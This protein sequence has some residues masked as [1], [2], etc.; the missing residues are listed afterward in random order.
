M[1]RLTTVRVILFGVGGV[2]SWCAESLVRTGLRHLTIVDSDLVCESNI[3]RQL[4]ATVETIGQP[5]VEVMRNRLLSINPE[6]D[7][8]AV[9]RRYTAE[10]AS[11]F[12]LDDY[13]FV[14][15]AI[16]SLADKA[17]LIL[18][19]T[20]VGK[21]NGRTRLFSSMGAA[22]R[23]DPLQVRKAEFWH[24]RGDAL[25]RALRNRF[26]RNEEFPAMKFQCVYSEQP[27][28]PQFSPSNF[29]FSTF[30]SQLPPP[31]GSLSQVTMVFGA[32][33]ASMVIENV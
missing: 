20:R 17:H 21:E 12:C 26:K 14:I 22:L 5:K 10:S 6:A 28:R 33:L 8:I 32:T 7:I 27:P 9:N 3:N 24:V 11:D 31:N 2:G 13:D 15:D 29:Q 19:A 16:D 25:A 4:M 1:Y 18:S 23:T 30:N